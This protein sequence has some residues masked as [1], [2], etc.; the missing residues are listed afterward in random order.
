M[1]DM[2]CFAATRL[3]ILPAFGGCHLFPS[4]FPSPASGDFVGGSSVLAGLTSSTA[5]SSSV[6]VPLVLAAN[7]APK[8]APP[9]PP[10]MPPSPDPNTNPTKPP[11]ASNIPDMFLAIGSFR[12]RNLSFPEVAITG[13]MNPPITVPR[14]APS[15]PPRQPLP[16]VFTG[17]LAIPRSSKPSN[18]NRICNQGIRTDL[19]TLAIL[20]SL[21]ALATIIGGIHAEIYHVSYSGDTIRY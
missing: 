21:F 18:V 2:R 19:Q 10:M 7:P 1:D 5:E 9:I 14:I 20:R 8:T 6:S 17:P 13:P 4:L 15:R 11:Q 16:I 12:E 3:P